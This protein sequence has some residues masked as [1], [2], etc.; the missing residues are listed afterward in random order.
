PRGLF[1]AQNSGVPMAKQLVD[2]T[3]NNGTHIGD[4]AKTAFEKVNA[5]FNELYGALGGGG[6]PQTLPPALPVSKGGTGGTTQAAARTGL[7][8]GT[9]ATKDIADLLSTSTGNVA[10]TGYCGFGGISSGGALW[11]WN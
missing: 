10:P 11:D 4:P 6:T 1:H 9:A 2:T 5:N 7:G 3:T 8:L